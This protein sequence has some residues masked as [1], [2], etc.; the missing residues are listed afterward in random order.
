MLQSIVAV[1]Q[2]ANAPWSSAIKSQTVSSETTSATKIHLE[3]KFK[4]E[5]NL[6]GVGH[7]AGYVSC[8]RE[9]RISGRSDL[10][11]RERTDRASR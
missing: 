8:R 4:S 1:P 2:P 6:P 7:R 9:G 10:T 11:G 3:D 5:L